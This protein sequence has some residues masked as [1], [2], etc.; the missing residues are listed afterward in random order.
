VLWLL[1]GGGLMDVVFLHAA[2]WVV[3]GFT[4]LA[5]VRWMLTDYRFDFTSGE[6]MTFLR[7]GAVLG[8]G[9]ALGIWL[10]M[11][12]L[13]LLRHVGS[14]LALIGQVGLAMNVMMIFVASA[15]SFMGAAV[16]V[17]SRSLVRGDP[18]LAS[19]G[20]VV[21]LVSLGAAA[22][23]GIAGLLYGQPLVV[24]VFGP[25]FAMAGALLG[26]CLLIG[27]I[28]LAHTGFAQMLVVKGHRWP[29]VCASAAGGLTLLLSLPPAVGSWGGYGAV[30]AIALAW[31]VRAVIVSAM[32][33]RMGKADD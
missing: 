21:L 28:I 1:N 27:G 31:A 5:M 9:G 10:S 22:V 20:K 18:R 12:P 32:A 15:Q 11:G 3:E 25:H 16:P 26:P 2:V 33:R 30:A 7:K 17:L 24:Y 6:A 4:G 14:D 29:G 23:A 19:Y 13:V 8:L